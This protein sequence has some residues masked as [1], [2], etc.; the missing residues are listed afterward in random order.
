MLQTA[1]TLSLPQT[2]NEI[3]DPSRAAL[4]VYDMQVGISRQVSQAPQ[5]VSTI[6]KLIVKAR[7]ARLRIAY[8][9]HLSAP[10]SWLGATATRTAMSWQR[11]QDPAE[12]T[13]PFPRDAAATQIVPELEPTADD[14]ILDKFAMSAF[15]GTY[16]DTMMRD[17]HL[18]TLIVCGIATEVG[19]D[20]TL[21]QAADLG[22]IPVMVSDACGAGNAEAGAR[23]V[24]ALAF[25][26]DTVM[27]ESQNLIAAL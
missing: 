2:L 22:F 26:G 19:I 5:I 11:L 18:S 23:A 15:V 17:C 3:V 20:P 8:T 1:L 24:A 13:F 27:T 4:L 14:L 9:R 21:R 25:A 16:L 6:G 10:R 12:V 7:E